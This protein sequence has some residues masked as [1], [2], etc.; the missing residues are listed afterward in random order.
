MRAF[1]VYFHEFKIRI[2]QTFVSLQQCSTQHTSF[3]MLRI[4]I[5]CLSLFSFLGVFAQKNS[6]NL[7]SSETV[8]NPIVSKGADPWVVR[9]GEMFHYCYVRKDTVFL[10]SV[11]RISEL[12]DAKE[13]VLWIPEK[14]TAYSKEVWAPELHFLEG[15]W[16]IYVAADDGKNENHR[17]HIIASEGASISS[18][19]KYF[20]ILTDKSDK[21]AIDGS[22]FKYNDKLYYIWSGWEGNK[23]VAQNI[24]IA[25]MSSPT[26]IK[27]ERILLSK[28]EKDWEK[29]GS[30]KD[31]PTINEGPEI[32]EK[33]GKL[34]LIYS[35]AGSW[36][37]HYCLGMLTL[38]GKDPLKAKNWKK[39]PEPVFESNEFVTSPG[40]ASFIKIKK[41]DYIVYHSARHKG[42]GWDRQVNIQPFEWKKGSPFFGKPIPFSESIGIDY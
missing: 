11:K 35:A 39:S 40:H 20:G 19:F 3:I 4:L 10:K 2:E 34:F 32:L 13:R 27:S 24:Y 21:W 41:K 31:L 15:K 1:K 9:E 6:I 38:T 5:F 30:N 17:M 29:R 33:N 26:S 7:T 18:A 25:E 14:G 22:P 28:P 16:Y 37:D 23:N 8:T 36:S 12:K 42:A